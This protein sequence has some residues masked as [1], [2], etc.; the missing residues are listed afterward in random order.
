VSVF[1][2]RHGETVDNAARI[3]QPA[4]SP[5]SARGGSQAR[6]LAARLR[7]EGVASI[8]TSDLPR[9]LATA[10]AIHEATGAPVV[11][12]PGLRERDYG[13]VRGTP[14][15]ELRDDIFGP[16]Y[17]PP[18]GE[19]WDAFHARVAEAWAR[20]VAGVRATPGHVVVVTHGL[21]CY[22]L[23][24]RHLT[25]PP[26][27][28]VGMRWANASVTVVEGVPPWRVRLLDDTAHLAEPRTGAP[29]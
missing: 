2:C 22:S 26:G 11:A 14:Y 7:A 8:R 23:L 3:V 28:V 19:S 15:A 9:A 1:L 13:T 25:A 10:E 20:I 6:R 29:V 21:V 18:G 17:L 27:A 12:D 24:A 16:D 4:D 5:L